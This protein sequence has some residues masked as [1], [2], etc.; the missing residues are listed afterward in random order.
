MGID[1]MTLEF[2]LN[3]RS[4]GM[5]FKDTITLGRQDLLIDYSDVEDLFHLYNIPHSEQTITEFYKKN[6]QF[7]DPLFEYLGATT[8]KSIDNSDFEGATIVHDL[9]K[10]I[11]DELK[12]Q[13]DTVID[14][15]TLEHVFNFPQAVKNCMEL[16][17]V[18]GHFIS[19][20][21]TN[22]YLGHGFY[23][24]GPELLYRVFS[25]ENGFKVKLMIYHE[26]GNDNLWYEVLD[27]KVVSHRV[28]IKSMY[29]GSLML[30]AK[31]T[32]ITNIFEKT[33]HQSDYADEWIRKP[34]KG[35]NLD[36]LNFWKGNT[37]P[38]KKKLRDRTKVFYQ[39]PLKKIKRLFLK[40]YIL[41]PKGLLPD[42]KYFILYKKP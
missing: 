32:K 11:N 28:E 26:H 25:E 3:T 38:K 1:R 40:K 6:N 34:D 31:K 14:G 22:N 19:I 42:Q 29:P 30:L 8:C 5:M 15:G 12:G 33:P 27:P 4:K 21:P 23:Q 2:I 13:F 35:A 17:K 39:Q 20:T 7:A 16:L 24:F 36:R 9:N 37:S 41:E 18:G 10:P